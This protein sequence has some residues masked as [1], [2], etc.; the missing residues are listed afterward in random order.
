MLYIVM[1]IVM[2]CLCGS[3][4]LDVDWLEYMGHI[5]DAIRMSIYM[6]SMFSRDK[7]CMSLWSN[8]Y[9]A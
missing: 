9:I 5:L 7:Q 8:M 2:S 6:I 3:V 4:F 1:F